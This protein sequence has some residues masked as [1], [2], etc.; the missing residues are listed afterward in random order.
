MPEPTV[1]EQV[2]REAA[3]AY[4]AMVYARCGI[5]AEPNEK[6][7]AHDADDPYLRTIVEVAY[8]AGFGVGRDYEASGGRR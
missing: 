2:Y 6:S 1:P 7:V 3:R 5:E 8:R 4:R